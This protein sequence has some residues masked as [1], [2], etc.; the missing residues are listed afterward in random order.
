[1]STPHNPVSP[2]EACGHKGAW[3]SP[4]C[5][6]LRVTLRHV[7]RCSSS[8]AWPRGAASASPASPPG[9][10]TSLCPQPQACC[11]PPMCDEHQPSLPR[12]PRRCPSLNQGHCRAPC[13]SVRLGLLSAVSRFFPLLCLSLL[14]AVLHGSPHFPTPMCHCWGSALPLPPHFRPR[15]ALPPSLLPGEAPP[16]APPSPP[17]TTHPFLCHPACHPGAQAERNAGEEGALTVVPTSG[18]LLPPHPSLPHT[19]GLPAHLP[20][21]GPG[22]WRQ[23]LQRKKK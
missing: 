7:G 13:L 14:L 20:L 23:V 12:A 11:E 2:Q 1:M 3:A 9:G 22:A 5:P 18:A 19:V 10:P 8:P 15:A 4:R 21:G 16:A 17:A 6:L